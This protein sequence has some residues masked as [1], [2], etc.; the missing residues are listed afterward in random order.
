MIFRISTDFLVAAEIRDHLF[1]RKA[2]AILQALLKNGRELALVPQTLAEFIHIVTNNE[3]A[4]KA[5]GV[6]EIVEFRP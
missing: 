3:R 6:F 2:D 4:Y 1:H 5:Y